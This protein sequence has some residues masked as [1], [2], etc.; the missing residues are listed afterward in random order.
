MPSLQAW[1]YKGGNKSSNNWFTM[2]H[3]T[4]YYIK[5]RSISPCEQ[6]EWYLIA[7]L[8]AGQ[9]EYLSYVHDLKTRLVQYSD[10]ACSRELVLT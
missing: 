3:I 2:L 5:S 8:K 7:I 9:S 4:L 10:P 6:S 1:A